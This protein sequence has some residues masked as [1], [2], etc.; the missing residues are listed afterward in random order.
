MENKFL[1]RFSNLLFYFS[2]LTFIISF[3]F[4]HNPPSGWYKQFLPNIGGKH[5]SDVFFLDS[6]TGW[7]VTPYRQQQNDTAFVLKTTNGGD[8][9]LIEYSRTAKY[10]GFERICFLNDN[11]GFT[12][13][14][15]DL[16]SG[17]T[18]LSKSTDGGSTW[19]SL[20]V[21]D[22]FAQF[23]DMSVL[24]E[25]TIWLASTSSGGGVF[26]TTNGGVSWNQQASPGDR[27]DKIYMYNSRIGFIGFNAGT[28]TT[29]KT[30]DGGFNWFTVIN[31]GFSDMCFID[32]LTGW[33]CNIFNVKKTTN[34]G[35][36]WILQELPQ[37]NDILS[38]MRS[39]S[40]LSKDTIW[41]TG[42]I[43]QFGIKFRGMVYRTTNGGDNW[44][45]QVPD[46]SIDIIRYDHITFVSP[47]IGWSYG[48]TSG[49]H[50]VTGGDSI[51]YPI[52]NI[53]Q[54]STKIPT[55]FELHQNYPNPFNPLT[56]IKYELKAVSFVKLRVFNIEG[57]EVKTIVNEK[58]NPGVYEAD[59]SVTEYSSS[60]SSGV[61]FYSMLAGDKIVDTRKMI[62][63]K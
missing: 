26:R 54:I 51:F 2:L 13:G 29:K 45:Y 15:N 38:G 59:F 47:L 17:Y 27:P 8:N 55:D 6:L 42:G 49:I 44:L 53:N 33:K 52:T 56:K 58:Q 48:T 16:F 20:N 57:K 28:P 4:A 30:T 34:G 40:V 39:I 60:I 32:S 23:N 22:P 46:T 5:I 61:Y 19:I 7:A 10:V 25:D 37:G 3:N 35:V 50:T 36:N 14:T 9:W 31:E 11:T 21:P 12:C 63:I 41:G 1:N 43:K 62:V 24:N 18:G